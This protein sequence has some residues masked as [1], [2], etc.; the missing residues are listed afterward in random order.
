MRGRT[1]IAIAHR[2]STILAADIIFVIDNGRLA[3]QGTHDEL[4]RAGG[5]YARL[6][7]QQFALS[8]VPTRRPSATV[9]SSRRALAGDGD[10][11]DD[12]DDEGAVAAGA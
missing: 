12:D 2:L 3:E 1:T 8:P 11:D 10:G 5:I 7:E 4:S 6:Y 9:L